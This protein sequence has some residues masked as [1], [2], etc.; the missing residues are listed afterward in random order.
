MLS[1][2]PVE[3]PTMRPRLILFAVSDW[4]S[5]LLKASYKAR[6]LV[7]EPFRTD[8]TAVEETQRREEEIRG[9]VRVLEEFLGG[10][11]SQNCREMVA[12]VVSLHQSGA[13]RN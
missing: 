12:H 9:A 5:V 3:A 6:M 10:R 4:F 8:G 13:D 1:I 11:L 7:R 2:W